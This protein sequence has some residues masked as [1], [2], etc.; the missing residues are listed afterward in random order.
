MR[1]AIPEGLRAKAQYALDYGDHLAFATSPLFV[2]IVFNVAGRET[3]PWDKLD[4]LA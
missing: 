2:S 1:P 4:G 3:P